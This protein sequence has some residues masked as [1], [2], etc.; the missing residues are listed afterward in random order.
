MCVRNT[1]L[2]DASLC[3]GLLP[4]C[5]QRERC[6]WSDVCVLLCVVVSHGLAALLPGPGTIL[7]SQ[8]SVHTNYCT[9]KV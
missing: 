6:S 8:V 7:L 9:L 5:P 1:S 2:C 3:G 4:W